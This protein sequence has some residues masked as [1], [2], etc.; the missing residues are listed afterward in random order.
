M[1]FEKIG[2]SLVIAAIGTLAGAPARAANIDIAQNPL[3]LLAPVKPAMVMGVDDSGS[4][5]SETVMPTNDGALWWHDDRESFT[6]FGTN[7]DNTDDVWYGDDRFNFNA[8]GSNNGTWQKYTYLFPNGGGR[9]LNTGSHHAVPPIPAFAF[10]RSHRFNPIYFDPSVDYEPLPSAG[11]DTFGD[12]DETAAKWDAVLGS[13]TVDLTENI[14]RDENDWVFRVEA[15]MTIPKGTIVDDPDQG[16]FCISDDLDWEPLP[17]DFTATDDDC[18]LAIE[19]FPAT[20]WLP[21]NE[22]PP[23]DFGWTGTPIFGGSAPDGTEMLG[24][25]IKPG[26]FAPGKYDEAIQNFANWFQYYRKRAHLTRAAIGRSFEGNEFLRVGAFEINNRNDVTMRDLSNTSERQAFFDSQYDLVAS[27]GTPNKQAVM[28]MGEQFERTGSNAPIVEAC[29]K[30]F[31]VLFSD[32]FSNTWTGAG[33]GNTDGASDSELFGTFLADSQSNTMADIAYHFYSR[34]L[35][36]DLTADLVPTPTACDQANPPLDLDCNDDPHMNFFAVLLGGVGLEFRVDEAATADPYENNPEWPTN[37]PTRNPAAIDDI[38]HGTL[39]ARGQTFS[40]DR[41]QD[42]IDAFSALL[43]EVASRIQPVGVSATSTRLDQDSLFYEAELDSTAWSGDLKAKRAEDGGVEWTASNAMPVSFSSRKIITSNGEGNQEPFDTGLSTT[44]RERIFGTAI[45]DPLEQNK[46]INY[47]RG[48]R[49]NEQQNGTG[50]L[51]DRDGV[52]G[53]IANSRP[54]FSGPRNEGWGRLDASYLAYIEEGGPKDSRTPLVLVGANDGMLHAFDAESGDEEFAYIPAA[55][56]N[57]LPLLADPDYSHQFY[58]D[59]QIRIGDAKISGGWKTVAVGGLGGGGKGVYAIDISSP[60]SPDLLWELS[61][62]DHSELG[63]VFGQ[64][65]ITRLGDG[66]WVAIFG[67]GYN[68]AAGTPH[69]FV[70]D[71]ASGTVLQKVEVGDSS[72]NGLSGVAAFLDPATRLFTSRIYAGDLDGNMWRFDFSD[73]GSASSAFGNSPLITAENNRPIAS[74]PSLAEHPGGGLMVYF[75]T[76]KLI[77]TADRI[78]GAS[79]FERFYAVR[80]RESRLGNNPGL[81]EASITTSGGDRVLAGADVTGDS[82]GWFLELGVGSAT[83][84]RVLS[85][86]EVVFGT[87]VFTTFEPDDDPCAAGGQRRIYITDALTGT[88]LLDQICANCGV[89]DVGLGAPVDPAIVIRPP[90]TR[91]SADDPP[92]DPFNPGDRGDGDQGPG[93]DDVGSRSGWCSELVIL[94]PG[95]G[96]VAAGRVCDGRQVWRQAR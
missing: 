38:W 75:G 28:H 8:R 42:L 94:V 12:A 29:Q 64:P 53:D 79:E 36:T 15:G 45:V 60:S 43:A 66:T 3:F 52:I 14:K 39:N 32:G 6:G 73:S 47:L 9:R 67:N 74:A 78:G 49:A 35:R 40:A 68:S 95:E 69:L 41:P 85:R 33:V 61:A 56:H 76:G 7:A 44:S 50:D 48:D 90:K 59:G 31:G 46:I 57:K 11:S 34:N 84:E 16:D 55:V 10:A 87:L 89:I 93:S 4:M 71:L 80:D 37:F 92:D 27:G 17:N 2:I 5:D 19:Y 88:G 30:N 18:R 21:L 65:V 51:R 22:A 63:H 82:D 72:G 26:N 81:D 62:E 23:A 20:F 96:F 83:G 13:D 91:E 58:V 54:R 24:Y 77:E 25:E 1:R 70:V 86:P